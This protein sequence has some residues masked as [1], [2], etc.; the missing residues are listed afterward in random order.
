M[1]TI[2]LDEELVIEEAGWVGRAVLF[3]VLL[4]VGAFAAA[5]AWL[6]FF[7]GDDETVRATE[8]FTVGRKTIA[9]TLLISGIADAELNS[10]LT[11]QSSGRVDAVNVKTGDTVREGD[12]L[13]TLESDDLQNAVASAQANLRTAQLRLEDLLEGST[14]AEIAA[15]EQAL[16]QAEATLVQAE[17]TY[18]D[19]LDGVEPADVA[20]AQQAV[21]AAESQLATARANRQALDD[22]P[23]ESDVISAE[24]AVASAQSALT[25]AQHALASAQ[26]SVTAAA[27]ALKSAEA[28]YCAADN[29][30]SF[31][32]APAT[33]ISSGDAALLDAALGGPNDTLAAGVISANVA[34]LNAVNSRNSAQAAVDSA[35]AG[36]DSAE[37]KLDALQD[38]PS[39]DDIAAADAAVA[40]AEAGLAAAQEKLTLAQQGATAYQLSTAAAAVES[41][42]AAVT[43]AS[44]RRDEAYRGPEANA[45]AQ[46]RQAVETARLSVEAAE[47]RLR[48]SRILA[49]FDGT[50]AAVNITPGEFVGLS[51]AEPAI[52][53]LTPNLMQ[54]K[55]DIGETD[56]ANVKVGQ[57]GGAR[58]DGI[59]GQ[60]YPFVISEVGLSPSSDQGVVTYPVTATLIVRDGAP[61]PSPGMNASG[62][63][64]VA[65]KPDVLAVPLRAIRRR[66]SEQIVDVRRDGQVIEQVVTTGVSD[67][68]SVEILEGL[69]E[70]DVIVL[71]AVRGAED[72]EAE[73]QPT[74]PGGIR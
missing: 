72:D 34:Y 30:P 47:I 71:P 62:Q 23:T 20:A 1:T 11:F 25:S 73:A 74:I 59:P 3:G 7:R 50:V 37:A 24:A 18:N 43:A 6:F 61:R 60:I 52:V 35:Q 17:N 42:R 48:Q 27:A 53:L 56:Y 10:N 57:A 58:F 68:E 69:A 13:A 14:G 16:A 54:L 21:S 9:T 36:L 31:C 28:S 19:L 4:L 64:I 63:L 45:I 5:G 55:M 66:G 67:T 70:G 15:A 26:N 65:S 44:L 2:D 49:P 12:V 22:A 46:Q 51:A 32:A 38:G 29:A 33:P 8:D 39:G 41:A 40:A